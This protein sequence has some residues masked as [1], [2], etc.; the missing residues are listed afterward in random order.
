MF[1]I[2]QNLV[3]NLTGHPVVQ[4]LHAKTSWIARFSSILFDINSYFMN[5]TSTT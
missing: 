3:I 2:Q 4:N 5:P 1:S